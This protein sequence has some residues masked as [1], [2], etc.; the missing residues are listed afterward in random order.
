MLGY[1]V[2]V[3]TKW[4]IRVRSGEWRR[5]VR[6]TYG[7]SWKGNV[8]N[9]IQHITN[10]KTSYLQISR[11]CPSR[12]SRKWKVGV[13][14]DWC[15]YE[16]RPT[17]PTAMRKCCNWTSKQTMRWLEQRASG[18]SKT[19]WTDHGSVSLKKVFTPWHHLAIHWVVHAWRMERWCSSTI[20]HVSICGRFPF[21]G[22]H[23][24]PTR[25]CDGIASAASHLL[26]NDKFI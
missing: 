18:E 13:V 11:G 12:N 6:Y 7:Y 21:V 4:N 2:H 26:Y 15:M 24:L 22:I 5:K 17:S 19:V 25:K 9:R 23:H 8:I 10:R 3:R 20:S 14:S 16:K 1:D